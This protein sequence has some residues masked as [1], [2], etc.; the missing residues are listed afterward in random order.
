MAT[1]RLRGPYQW[2]VIIRRRGYPAQSKTFETKAKAEAWARAIESEMDHGSFISRAEAEG[3]TLTECMR[4]YLQEVTPRKK[5][6]KQEA[7]KARNILRHSISQLF[8]A[9]VRGSDVAKYRDDRLAAGKKASTVVKELALISHLFN[10]ARREWKMES[11]RNP[12]EAVSKPSVNNTRDRRFVGDEEERL[13][14]ACRASQNHWLELCVI[15]AIE[16][17]QRRGRIRQMRWENVSFDRRVIYMPD[18]VSANK[19][20]PPELPL[21]RRAIAALEPLR[22]DEGAIIESSDNALRLAYNRARVRA[23]LDDLR[24]HD[25]RHEATSRFFEKGLHPMQVAAITGHKSDSML[26]RYTHLRA[27]DLAKMLG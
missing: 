3:T 21:S 14:S 8:M 16:T 2:Q 5:G 24:F 26:R 27:E 15:L 13:L 19:N 4:R 12:V 6:A 11:L 23:G 9:N 10:T 18:E 17:G 7:M 22:K 25:L 20:A 1:I